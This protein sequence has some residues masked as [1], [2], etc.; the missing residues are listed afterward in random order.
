MY[1]Y[2]DV[3]TT[4]VIHEKPYFLLNFITV[5]PASLLTRFFFLHVIHV[6]AFILS[7]RNFSHPFRHCYVLRGKLIAANAFSILNF[8]NHHFW[9]NVNTFKHLHLSPHAFFQFYHFLAPFFVTS[10]KRNTFMLNQF[11][12]HHH[13]IVSTHSLAHFF[14]QPIQSAHSSIVLP[15]CFHLL[16]FKTHFT[17]PSITSNLS[18][19]ISRQCFLHHFPVVAFNSFSHCSALT[20]INSSTCCVLSLFSIT[21]INKQQHTFF[22]FSAKSSFPIFHVICS[23]SAFPAI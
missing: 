19:S 22:H 21:A 5:F 9:S 10:S 1:F 15:F 18:A 12:Y 23:Q 3:T 16:L 6:V 7:Y 14:P 20:S 13:N 4:K 2:C 8:S 11:H 17:H